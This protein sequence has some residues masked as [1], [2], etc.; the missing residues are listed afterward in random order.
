MNFIFPFFIRRYRTDGL[1]N[2]KY[3]LVKKMEAKL[4]TN[5]TVQLEHTEYSQKFKV[6]A[7]A[8]GKRF[9]NYIHQI[10]RERTN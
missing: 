2:L 6:V 10:A 8:P 1:N 3:S 5:L 9:K 7:Q 4:Y